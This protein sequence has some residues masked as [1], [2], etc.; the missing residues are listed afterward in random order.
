MAGKNRRTG[1]RL[2]TDL[3]WGQT[4]KKVLF[5]T[6]GILGSFNT[7]SRLNSAQA[8][9][10]LGGLPRKERHRIISRDTTAA[11]RLI[12]R[13]LTA[14]LLSMG[15]E[16]YD[17]EIESIPI[18]R[19]STRFISADM[20]IYV[21]ISPMTGLQFVQIKIFNKLGFQISV[22]E[23]KK[24]RTSFSGGITRERTLS[25][26]ASWSTHTPS[27]VV[28]GEC[29]EIRQPRH[30]RKEKFSVIVDCFNGATSYIF[31]DLFVSLGCSVSV[32]RGQ[33]KETRARRSSGSRHARRWRGS[34]TWP[35]RTARSASSS[36][37]GEH[38]TI[39][40]ERGTRFPLT[41]RARS[42]RCII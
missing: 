34:S 29:E 6:D 14:G 18:N 37:H 19:Y 33:I 27:R 8:R 23:E 41:K 24:S 1:T 10:G 32:L 5:G 4:E 38:L 7:K 22:A 26:S 30:A 16:V 25:R 20:G 2:T 21:Q 31:P 42:S 17:M 40:D 13:A 36:P 9:F 12:K 39:I 35:A 28:H 15:V 11:A 3:I